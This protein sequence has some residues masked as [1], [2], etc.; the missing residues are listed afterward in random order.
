[1]P[2]ALDRAVKLP[3]TEEEE[4]QD[5]DAMDIDEEEDEKEMRREVGID[6]V[7][8]QGTPKRMLSGELWF[9]IQCIEFLGACISEKALRYTTKYP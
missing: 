1:L 3:G 7:A 9:V 5:A 6:P 2:I 8:G 4:E